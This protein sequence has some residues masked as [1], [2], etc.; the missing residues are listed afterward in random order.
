MGPQARIR[1]GASDVCRQWRSPALALLMLVSLTQVA[2]AQGH[3][4]PVPGRHIYDQAGVLTPSEQSDLEARAA[5]VERAGAPVVVYLQRRDASSAQ[6]QQ[7]AR[8]LMDAWNIESRPQAKDGLVLLLNLKPSDRAHGQVAL[9]AGRSLARGNLPQRELDRIYRQVMLPYLSGGQTAAGIAAGLDAV[10]QDL[11]HGPPPAPPLSPL[12]RFAVDVSKGPANLVTAFGAVALLFAALRAWQ[13]RATGSSPLLATT[14]V[15]SELAP[16]LAGG[17]VEGRVTNDQMTATIL[18]LAQRGALSIEPA[19][20]RQV[21]IRLG[22]GGAV[23]PGWEA[24]LWDT[25]RSQ[26]DRTGVIG[27]SDLAGISGHWGDAKMALRDELRSRGWFDASISARRRTLLIIG[28]VAASVAAIGLALAWIEP[29]P[30]QFL[31]PTLL[32]L[33]SAAELVLVYNIAE[34]TDTGEA[35]AAPWRGYRSGLRQAARDTASPLDL[36]RVMPYAVA[37][38][39]SRSL[40]RR[41]KVASAAGYAP[42]WLGPTMRERAWEGGFY[43]YWIALHAG[44]SP[45][46]PSSGGSSASS[47]GAGAGG[48]F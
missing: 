35:A 19:G 20:Q 47:G 4:I 27:S 38:G 1:R 39:I 23:K 31:G 32:V 15:P 48:G 7:D 40:G 33:A 37:L 42:A 45:S 3:G 17:L 12:L 21:Q 34:R 41:L 29:A 36:D 2:L 43:P 10:Q 16:A 30:G 11:E 26:A 18:D 13:R 25:L 6:T 24:A 28:I 8:S 5:S 44:M 22:N 14:A 9:Y 46:T